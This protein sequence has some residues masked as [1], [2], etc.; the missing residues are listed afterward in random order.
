[1]KCGCYIVTIYKQ[2]CYFIILSFVSP[3]NNALED[4]P[5]EPYVAS[6]TLPR[7]HTILHSL[8]TCTLDT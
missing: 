4:V 7:C 2:E 3:I 1:M 5:D 6:K 8:P